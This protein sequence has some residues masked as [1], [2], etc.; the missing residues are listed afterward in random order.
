MRK[1]F[2]LVEL[3]IVLVII[4]LLIGGILAAQ[5]MISTARID[6]SLTQ[7]SQY[8]ASINNFKTKLGSLPG[9]SDALD[10]TGN[11]NGEISSEPPEPEY[12]WYHLSVGVSLKNKSGSDYVRLTGT[13]T[14][15]M[16]PK[17]ALDQNNSDIPDPSGGG[18]GTGRACLSTYLSGTNAAT[19]NYLTYTGLSAAATF[20]IGDSLGDPVKAKDVLALDMKLDDGEPLTGNFTAWSDPTGGFGLP[21]CVS[22]SDYD[23]SDEKYRCSFSIS[24]QGLNL[25]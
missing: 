3:S 12:F 21:S 22:G 10:H 14:E 24:F 6:R 20:M 13:P 19:G 23:L 25:E 18:G 15:D 17:L 16:C 2:T 8:T 5:S 11:N 1:G 9:D 4:G 7:I